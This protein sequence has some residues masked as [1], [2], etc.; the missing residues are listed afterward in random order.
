M[1]LPLPVRI[2]NSAARA[3]EEAAAWW[4]AN[5]PKSPDAFVSDLEN[6]LKLIALHPEIGAYFHGFG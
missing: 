1:N 4:E 6:A 3:I 2:V 5:R